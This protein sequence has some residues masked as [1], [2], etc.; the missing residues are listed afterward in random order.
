MGIFFGRLTTFKSSATLL[1]WKQLLTKLP[2]VR[3]LVVDPLQ[4]MDTPVQAKSLAPPTKV[5]I[6]IIN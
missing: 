6:P 5:I 2:E 1:S 3:T 4:S